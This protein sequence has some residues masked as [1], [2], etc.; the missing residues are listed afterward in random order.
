[1]AVS[2]EHLRQAVD[3]VFEAMKRRERRRA[4]GGFLARLVIIEAL[5]WSMILVVEFVHTVPFPWTRFAVISFF[6]AL[7]ASPDPGGRFYG[8]RS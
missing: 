7:V 8:R 6:A 1:V 5:L 3:Q 4:V 2:E